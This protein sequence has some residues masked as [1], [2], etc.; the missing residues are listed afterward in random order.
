MYFIAQLGKEDHTEQTRK[1][2]RYEKLF[3]Y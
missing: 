1:N 3:V 2:S